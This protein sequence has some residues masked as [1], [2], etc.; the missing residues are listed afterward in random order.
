MSISFRGR[1]D[2]QEIVNLLSDLV[3]I[4]SINPFTGTLGIDAMARRI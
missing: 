3:R 1:A 2:E 4:N